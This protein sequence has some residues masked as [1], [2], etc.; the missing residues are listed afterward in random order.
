MGFS[1]GGLTK[2]A[3]LGLVDD[4]FGTDAA[5]KAGLQGQREGMAAEERMFGKG[6]AFQQKIFDWQKE[7]AAPFREAGLG[8]LG[9]FQDK[10]KQG[11]KFDPLGDAVYKA[12]VSELDKQLASSQAARGMKFSGSTLKSLRDITAG[13]L[14]ASY[15]RQYG[16][17]SDTL[18][19]LGNIVNVGQGSTMN[20]SNI[21]ASVASQVGQGYQNL[22]SSLAQGYQNMGAIRAQQ[23]TA[24]FQNLMSIGTTAGGLM[25]GAGAMGY[26]PFGVA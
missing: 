20:L 19:N 16:A 17:W 7:Q 5:A 25:M 3:T 24:P 4:P 12:R 2:I 15:G 22:G 1:L 6:L 14:G 9:T 23:A 8:A 21:G 10:L 13:E 26:K 11:F 18:A